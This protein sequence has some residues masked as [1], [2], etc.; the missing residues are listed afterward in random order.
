MTRADSSVVVVTL[1]RNLPARTVQSDLIQPQL[2][3]EK[4]A[5]RGP[6][7]VNGSALLGSVTRKTELTD[8]LTRRLCD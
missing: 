8:R 3:L 7:Q 5:K 6:V 4:P 2:N 1:N